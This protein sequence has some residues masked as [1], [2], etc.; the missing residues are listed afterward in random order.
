MARRP[1]GRCSRRWSPSMS[2]GAIVVSGPVVPFLARRFSLERIG[3]GE[4]E[5]WRVLRMEEMSAGWSTTRF[6]GRA[7]ELGVLRRAASFAERGHGQIVGIVGEAGVG[8]SRLVREAIR[9]LQGW[10][11]LAAGGAPYTKETPGAPLVELLRACATSSP[12][13][14][15]R[16]AESASCER[17]RPTPRVAVLPPILDLLG[18]L[19]RDHPFRNSDPAQRR[20]RTLDAV[21]QMLL[22]ASRAQVVVPGRRGSA[23]DRCRDPGGSRQPRREHARRHGS[24][25]SSTTGPSTGTAGAARPIY[26]QLRPRRAAG[27]ERRRAAER[28][29]RPTIPGSIRSSSCSSDE[30]NPFFLEESI[31]TLVETSALAGER[32]AYRLTRPVEAIAGPADG[33]GDPGGPDRPAPAGGQAPPPDRLGHRQG[34]ALR[35]AP[36]RGGARRRRRCS[37]GL[38]RLQAA[39]FLYETR[40]LS[41][42]RVHLQACAHP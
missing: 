2:P 25:C 10:R 23:L 32:G 12:R 34:R 3:A 6:V 37:R 30:G 5:A 40:A 31:R 15:P 27:R 9:G 26:S 7:S 11:V 13:M 18:A 35:A 19:P 38:D 1:P 16:T 42:S 21:R 8:K 28:P 39:E 36:G 20:Q 17:C 4:R 24:S 33:A 41:G 14:P 29:P 22:A